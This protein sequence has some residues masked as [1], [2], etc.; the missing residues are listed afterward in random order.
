MNSEQINRALITLWDKHRSFNG[1]PT[2]NDMKETKD[3]LENILRM[4]QPFEIFTRDNILRVLVLN[5]KYQAVK[6][7]WLSVYIEEKNL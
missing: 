6:P 3:S 2:I 7:S 1:Y 5:R 4:D